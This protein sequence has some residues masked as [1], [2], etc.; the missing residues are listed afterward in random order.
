MN[1]G[2]QTPP[3]IDHVRRV[4]RDAGLDVRED[5]SFLGDG[6]EMWA[7][8]AGDLVVRLPKDSNDA[9]VIEKLRR[10]ARV[11]QFIA[12]HLPLPISVLDLHETPAGVIFSTHRLVPGVP[13]RE[14]KRPAAP[15]FGAAL[16]RFLHALHAI[17]IAELAA[18][19]VEVVDGPVLRQRL[20]ERYESFARRAFPLI[21]CEAR[22]HV[23]N[24]FEALINDPATFDYQPALIHNDIDE[25]NAVA[26]SE[27]GEL[28]G[29]IDFGDA[30]I[31]NPAFDYAPA[32]IGMFERLGVASELPDL[33][34]EGGLL[35]SHLGHLPD[36]LRVA[37]PLNDITH[38]L[39]IND[40]DF[41]AEGIR[42]PQRGRPLRHEVLTTRGHESVLTYH[43]ERIDGVRLSV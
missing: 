9:E 21:S 2:P 40:P 4:L 14:L 8:L 17:P 38:G 15:G 13:L 3:S 27:T 28:T 31:C 39:E 12:P 42:L 16:G 34:R 37:W 33:F 43:C 25:R 29:I 32:V 20:I 18:L 23:I 10:E 11:S 1:P 22:T 19:G 35:E 5:V 6:W 26:D 24:V 30:E 41:V 36:F 7:F